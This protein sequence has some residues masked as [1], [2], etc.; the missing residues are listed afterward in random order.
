MDDL[1]RIL[2]MWFQPTELENVRK[3]LHTIQ[4]SY[5]KRSGSCSSRQLN[6]LV[7]IT[8]SKLFEEI[9]TRKYRYEEFAVKK[10]RLLVCVK[11]PLSHKRNLFFQS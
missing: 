10:V 3:Y 8:D 2:S 7:A 5:P 9:V 4:R 11:K 1:G 6:K